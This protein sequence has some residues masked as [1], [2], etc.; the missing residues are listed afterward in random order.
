MCESVCVSVCVSLSHDVEH[1]DTSTDIVL[2]KL[3]GGGDVCG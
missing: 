3:G 2:A 1:G